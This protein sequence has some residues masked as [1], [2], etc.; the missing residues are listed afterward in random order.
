MTRNAQHTAGPWYVA[1]GSIY[2]DPTGDAMCIGHAD[3]N[4]PETS[5]TERDA[6]VALMA[7]APELLDALKATLARIE[8]RK[9]FFD[10]D[11]ESLRALIARI[12]GTRKEAG[13]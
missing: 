1:Y 8:E 2:T 4:E 10:A 5:P 7:S 13:Q 11:L 12:E 3:R 9:P 6:N